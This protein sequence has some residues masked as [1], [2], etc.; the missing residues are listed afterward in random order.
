[1]PLIKCTE[2]GIERSNQVGSACPKCGH[3][4]GAEEEQNKKEDY[5]EK[6]ILKHRGSI[7]MVWFLAV[8]WLIGL[9]SGINSMNRTDEWNNDPKKVRLTGGKA[10]YTN[11]Y[12]FFISSCAS[13][14]GAF[15]NASQA[16]KITDEL[17]K[18]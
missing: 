4:I 6:L 18:L 3:V 15:Y 11:A 17:E 1:M 16:S 8:F 9:I 5:K 7:T 14:L 12:L 2:C 10:S 13:G